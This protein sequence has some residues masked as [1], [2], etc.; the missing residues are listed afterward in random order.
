LAETQNAHEMRISR[1]EDEG[2]GH[3]GVL[4]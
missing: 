2:K 4:R 1:L 3:H